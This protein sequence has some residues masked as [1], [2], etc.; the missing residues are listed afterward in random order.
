[1][2]KKR[3]LIILGLLIALVPFLGLPREFREVL[4]VILGLIVSTL[5]FL[6]KRKLTQEEKGA[7]NLPPNIS[8][9]GIP[10]NGDKPKVPTI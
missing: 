7:E 9:S 3:T 8:S 2:T 5:A 6:L 4:T 10:T 1:M